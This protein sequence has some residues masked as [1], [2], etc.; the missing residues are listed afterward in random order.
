VSYSVQQVVWYLHL[1]FRGTTA[2]ELFNA[3]QKLQTLMELKPFDN[4]NYLMS[5]DV[6][7]MPGGEKRVTLK[8]VYGDSM[9]LRQGVLANNIWIYWTF[10]PAVEI[11]QFLIPY[12]KDLWRNFFNV[13]FDSVLRT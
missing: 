12:D 13:A 10:D 5:V 7:N 4:Y 3:F 8:G 1:I 11:R 9:V 2:E 6:A